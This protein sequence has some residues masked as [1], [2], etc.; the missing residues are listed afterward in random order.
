MK[1][2]KKSFHLETITNKLDDE[3]EYC[4]KVIEAVEKEEIIRNYPN[5]KET[6]N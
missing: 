2:W 6:L 4:Q 1:E 3:L 5:V